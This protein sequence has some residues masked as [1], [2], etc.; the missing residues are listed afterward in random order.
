MNTLPLLHSL[1]ASPINPALQTHDIVLKG[2]VSITTQSALTPHGVVSKQGFKHFPLKQASP[3]VHSESV[4]QSGSKG[5]AEIKSF[6][7]LLIFLESI[8]QV[9][10]LQERSGFPA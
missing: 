1:S 2:N 6:S 5:G 9:P 4:V 8:I 10:L 3:V 7:K